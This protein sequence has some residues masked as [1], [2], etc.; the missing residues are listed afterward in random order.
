MLIFGKPVPYGTRVMN[1]GV[2]APSEYTKF[3]SALAGV[4]VYSGTFS[5]TAGSLT[6]YVRLL[7]AVDVIIVK[8][9]AYA[10]VSIDPKK[11]FN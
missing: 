7:I 4:I 1:A 3:L 8:F 5:T 6:R 11:A 10:G 9:V 2:V